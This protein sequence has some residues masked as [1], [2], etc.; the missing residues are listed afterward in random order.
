VGSVLGLF[1]AARIIGALLARFETS[2]YFV[3][4]GLILG[5]I[6]ILYDIGVADGLAAAFTSGDAK[7]IVRDMILAAASLTLGYVC[8]R[9][10]SSKKKDIIT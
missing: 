1:T 10:M 3:V 8:T 2:V 9:L 5:A 6:Y 7:I 4:M